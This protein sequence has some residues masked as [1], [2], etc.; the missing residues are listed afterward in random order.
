MYVSM[1]DE[2]LLEQTKQWNSQAPLKSEQAFEALYMRWKKPLYLYLLHL[3]HY[4]KDNTEQVLSD[5]FL[6]LYEYNIFY[7]RGCLF[8]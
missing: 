8:G 3:L 7:W 5:V 2:Q 1:L 4:Q 6:L